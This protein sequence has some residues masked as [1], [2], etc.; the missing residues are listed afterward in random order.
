MVSR[1]SWPIQDEDI[2]LSLPDG[3]KIPAGKVCKLQRSLYGL[4]PA[5]RQWNQEFTAKLLLFGFTQ[6]QHDHN[7]FLKPTNTGVIMLLVYVDNVLIASPIESLITPIKAYM[8][9]LFTIKDLAK[10][11]LVWS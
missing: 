9:D 3:Y 11:F 6:C 1:Y 5:S 8:H 10:H 4:E 7:L 2:Y